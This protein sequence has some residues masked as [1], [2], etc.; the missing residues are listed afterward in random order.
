MNSDSREGLTTGPYLYRRL[1]LAGKTV[2]ELVGDGHT[3]FGSAVA[4]LD[5][6]SRYRRVLRPAI[7]LAVDR[8]QLRPPDVDSPRQVAC[9]RAFDSFSDMARVTCDLTITA[10][11]VLALGP[12]RPTRICMLG[13]DPQGTPV[14]F[15][16]VRTASGHAEQLAHEVHALSQECPAAASFRRPILLGQ[17]TN[18]QESLLMTDVPTGARRLPEW[19]SV[20]RSLRADSVATETIVLGEQQWF[21]DALLREGLRPI[22]GELMDLEEAQVGAANAH[23]DVRPSNVLV[24]SGESWLLDWESF[25][26]GAPWLTDLVMASAVGDRST[27]TDLISSSCRPDVVAAAAF[28]ATHLQPKVADIVIN[29]LVGTRS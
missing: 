21:A 19:A 16:K 29:A 7:G 15:C 14:A 28:L 13:L 6:T 9:L 3:K 23:V 24:A 5:P 1:A 12:W 11:L 4:T 20:I 2:V 25:A 17:T 18:G 22:V 27:L 26:S 8:V 10:A